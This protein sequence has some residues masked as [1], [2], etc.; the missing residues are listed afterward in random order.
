MVKPSLQIWRDLAAQLVAPAPLVQMA[1]AVLTACK[2][3]GALPVL[4]AR[5]VLLVQLVPKAPLALLARM[6]RPERSDLKVQLVLGEIQARQV[7]KASRV[8]PEPSE[9]PALKAL[10]VHRAQPA[11]LAHRHQ[12]DLFPSWLKKRR[13]KTTAI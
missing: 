11:P 13:F 5:L 9:P 6:V 1:R 4:L 2:D 3:H 10:R 12:S 7:R 8:T